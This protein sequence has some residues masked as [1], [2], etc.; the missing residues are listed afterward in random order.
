MG[1]QGMNRENSGTMDR[2]IIPGLRNRK[3][4]GVLAL[5]YVALFALAGYLESIRI[6][7]YWP[8][9]L[10][11]VGAVTWIAIMLVL[12]FLVVQYFFGLDISL[13]WRP[14]RRFSL[15]AMLLFWVPYISL[16]VWYFTQMEWLNQRR[17]WRMDNPTAVR[18]TRGKAPPGLLR[19]MGD[20]GESRIEIKN[21]TKDEIAEAKRLFPEATV[22]AAPEPDRTQGK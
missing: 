19:L 5:V 6:E 13:L 10:L 1:D 7:D 16:F 12:P 22:V 3:L 18:T 15:R 14:L 11:I 4:A 2:V 17:D 21:A 20:P 9:W 8:T